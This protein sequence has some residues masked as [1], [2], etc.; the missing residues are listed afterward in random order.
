MAW[1]L[2]SGGC[3]AKVALNRLGRQAAEKLLPVGAGMLMGSSHMWWLS[4]VPIN[5]NKR[6]HG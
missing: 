1:I 6:I 5:A 4:Q 2:L 3:L